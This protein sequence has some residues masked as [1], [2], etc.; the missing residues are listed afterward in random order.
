M[1]AIHSG[2]AVDDGSPYRGWVV[3][4]FIDSEQG[5]RHTSDVSI[6]WG[7]HPAGWVREKWMTGETRTTFSMLIS[8]RFRIQLSEGDFLLTKPGDYLM[9]GPG[10]DHIAQAEED[11]V[12]LTVRWQEPE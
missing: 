12:V 10:V 3:G 6:K 4:N 9:W 7:I 5:I 1:A 11:S 2:N 8:G